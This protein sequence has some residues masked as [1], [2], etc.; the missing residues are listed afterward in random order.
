MDSISKG[1][2]GSLITEKAFVYN[3][4]NVFKPA[5]ENGKVDMIVEKNNQYWK[6]QIKTIQVEKS[7]KNSTR[8]VIPV[9]K[10]SH[11]MGE[12][13]ISYYSSTIVDYFIGVDIETEDIY[14]IPSEITEQYKSSIGI[15]K[16]QFFK[17]NFKLKGISEEVDNEEIQ[18]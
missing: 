7:G 12:Y 6:L 17:N 18:L 8:K 11:N 3:N 2:L 4:F 1:Y 15:T 13:K 5:T 14:I 16:V 10:I 9:R